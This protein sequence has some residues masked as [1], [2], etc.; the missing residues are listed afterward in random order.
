[1]WK[2]RGINKRTF[3]IQV[4]SFLYQKKL[5]SLQGWRRPNSQLILSN[6]RTRIAQSNNQT[7]SDLERNEAV[8]TLMCITAFDSR[9]E[10]RNKDAISTN[11]GWFKKPR[12]E[13]KRWLNSKNITRDEYEYIKEINKKFD[14]MDLLLSDCRGSK[15]FFKI[16]L[17][18]INKKTIIPEENSEMTY[19]DRYIVNEIILDLRQLIKVYKS[20]IV[21]NHINATLLKESVQKRITFPRY[22]ELFG[23][24]KVI[25]TVYDGPRIFGTSE[26]KIFGLLE[27]CSPLLL[28]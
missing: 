8:A 16:L 1:M 2:T 5:S 25:K 22:I 11:N 21:I 20:Q 3:Y 23:N 14:N 10:L 12:Y 17:D 9:E 24:S 4:D 26:N 13:I 19:L 18:E 6:V 28:Q 27:E 7:L 15:A